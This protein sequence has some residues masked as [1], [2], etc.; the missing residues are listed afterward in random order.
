MKTCWI[1]LLF[2]WIPFYSFAQNAIISGK[3]LD[4]NTNTPLQSANISIYSHGKA[5]GNI[6]NEE[7]AFVLV[8][9]KAIDSVKFSM[10]GYANQ[11]IS[12]S[13][14]TDTGA[15]II[16]MEAKPVVLDEVFIKPMSAYE[17]VL[18]AVKSTAGLLP[19][20]DY[21]NTLFY[22]EIIKNKTDYFSVA[23]A[24]FNTQYSR[25]DKS[26][27][28]RL[29]RGRSKED[30][31]ATSLFEDFHPGGG[32]E[33]LSE[34]SFSYSFPDF[35]NPSKMKWF[36]YKKNSV[37]EFDARR[38]F[39]I[40]F[41]QK[42]NE[43]KALEKGKIYI[44]AE[45]YAIIKYEAYNSPRGRPYI[46][47]LSG[48]DKIFAEILNIDFKK[49]GWLKEVS[50]TKANGHLVINNAR[51]IYYID[52]KQ[53]KKNLDLDLTITT[54]SAVTD[55]SFTI[56]NPITAKDKWN[57]KTII[58][59]LPSDYDPGFWGSNNIISPGDSLKNILNSISKKNKEVPTT[60]ID[61]GWQYFQ[62]NTFVA[63]QQHDSIILVPLMKS[64]WKDDE[65]GSMIFRN[66]SGDFTAETYVSLVKRSSVSEE[67]DMGFQQSGLIVRD[68]AAGSENNI[69]VCI[70]TGGN[71][72]PKFFSR[73]TEDGKS[74][75]TVDQIDSLKGYLKLEKKGTAIATYFRADSV[76]KWTTINSYQ[77]HWPQN[78]LQV[79]LML[80]AHFSGSGPRM[81]PDIKAVFTKFSVI[82]DET[83]DQFKSGN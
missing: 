15:V 19:R 2:Y 16:L 61:T 47:S 62:A 32:P 12:L 24:I 5:S 23:E 58:A 59:N 65:T 73:N 38:V 76:S 22:R 71:S 21:E 67:P 28:L 34:L 35:L 72:R 79:G 53:P 14:P 51:E 55:N 41:D 60:A 29:I 45:D 4:K 40:N 10:I 48:T 30:V 66:I 9:T 57:M 81:K 17:L 8:N 7:G 39:V 43:H 37:T 74:K 70:G 6:T 31:T 3:V 26:Y 18:Q 68:A 80:M 1:I 52:Y 27:K 11:V 46:K 63:A 33:G 69:I 50:F 56:A 42:E 77:V 20:N 54:E 49:K 83:Q 13:S 36:E 75:P 25:A 64:N 82:Q 78:K 44:D